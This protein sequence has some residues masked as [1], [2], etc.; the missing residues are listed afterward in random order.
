MS[1]IGD[2]WRGV[3]KQLTADEVV[4]SHIVMA[5][6]RDSSSR[7]PAIRPEI[8]AS[9]PQDP[10]EV[11]PESPAA[12]APPAWSDV[13]PFHFASLVADMQRRGEDMTHWEVQDGRDLGVSEHGHCVAFQLHKTGTSAT[14]LVELTLFRG[15]LASVRVH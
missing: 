2:L 12:I 15:K 10:R 3:T 14:I 6:M 13:F 9:T 4:P 5:R 7:L 11:P 1:T 8:K